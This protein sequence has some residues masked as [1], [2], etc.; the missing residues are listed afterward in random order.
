MSSPGPS[1]SDAQGTLPWII[2]PGTYKWVDNIFDKPIKQWGAVF[3]LIMCFLCI[4]V[5]FILILSSGTT[6]E[7]TFSSYFKDAMRKKLLNLSV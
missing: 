7:Q 4:M 3:A 2:Q 1:P 6:S 5:G